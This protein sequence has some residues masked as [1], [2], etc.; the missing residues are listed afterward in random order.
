MQ[1][2]GVDFD[3]AFAP[4]VNW[5]T[6]KMI[7]I[8]SQ[9]LYLTTAQFDY[10]AAFIQSDLSEDVF[11]EMPRGFGIQGHVFKLKKSL[12]GLL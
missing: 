11:C 2:E 3:E 7:L 4:I 9:L 1:I 12:Y 6:V 8:L 10:T 5:I